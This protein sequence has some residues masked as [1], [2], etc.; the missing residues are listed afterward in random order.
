MALC[1]L[2]LHPDHRPLRGHPV[3]GPH[4]HWHQPNAGSLAQ[5]APGCACEERRHSHVKV[6]PVCAFVPAM[7]CPAAHGW[8]GGGDLFP[9]DVPR[10][11]LPCVAREAAPT[12]Q[13]PAWHRAECRV[14][15][16]ALSVLPCRPSLCSRDPE[17]CERRLVQLFAASG[18]HSLLL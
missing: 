11:K 5:L 10:A 8:D 2:F 17:M 15:A 18:T 12:L 16:G 13:L 14:L 6:L 9:A 7:R 1:S 3:I 4:S